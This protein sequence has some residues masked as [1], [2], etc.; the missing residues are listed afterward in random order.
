MQIMQHDQLI[1]T[2]WKDTKMY[3][4]AKV[5][6]YNYTI[7]NKQYCLCSCRYMMHEINTILF[8]IYRYTFLVQTQIPLVMA[9]L[10][11]E[12]GKVILLRLCVPHLLL[13]TKDI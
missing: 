6:E 2:A 9:L 7:Q 4:Y 13:H 10:C 1:A 3:T 5:L 12:S 8:Q 11:D